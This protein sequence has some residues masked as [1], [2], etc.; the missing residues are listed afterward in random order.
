ME[1]IALIIAG[2]ATVLGYILA[3]FAPI[4]IMIFCVM[5]IIDIFKKD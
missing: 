4:G 3:L 1:T 2:A 5:Y